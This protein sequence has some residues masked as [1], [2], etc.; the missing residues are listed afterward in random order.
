MRQLDLSNYTVHL[1]NQDGKY[2]DSPYEVKDSLIEL[3]MARDLQLSGTEL[4]KRNELA[5]RILNCEDGHILLE[6][7]EW[8]KLERAINTIK[9][10]SRAD[11]ELVRRILEAPKIEV[12]E[13]K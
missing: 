11:V 10:L 7:E 4:L 8:G 5:Q 3:M 13:K 6:E 2:V 9:G 12:E 1:R